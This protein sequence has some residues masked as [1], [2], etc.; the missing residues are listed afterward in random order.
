MG[1]YKEHGTADADDDIPSL[2]SSF[3]M[4]PVDN[5]PDEEDHDHGSLKADEAVLYIVGPCPLSAFN[6]DKVS[7]LVQ[8]GL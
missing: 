8:I 3:V 5:G 4:S 7:E 2:V 1:T 6:S